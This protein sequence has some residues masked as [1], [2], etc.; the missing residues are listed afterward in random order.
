MSLSDSISV[1]N[2]L[3]DAPSPPIQFTSKQLESLPAIANGYARSLDFDLLPITGRWVT[4]EEAW[5][6]I[7]VELK[8]SGAGSTFSGVSPAIA[9]KGSVLS[10]IDGISIKTSA[11][12]SLVEE[13]HSTV[14]ANHLRL[15][16]ERPSN[17]FVSNVD[18][19]Q[20]A[21]DRCESDVQSG[22]DTAAAIANPSLARYAAA[23]GVAGNGDNAYYNKGFATRRTKLL[24]SLIVPQGGVLVNTGLKTVLN[25]KLS[26]IHSFFEAMNFPIVN[27][28]LQMTFYCNFTGSGNSSYLP[29]CRG[30]EPTLVAGGAVHA[31]D[32]P[33]IKADVSIDVP[34]IWYH[35]L[36][37]SPEQNSLVQAQLEKG[38]VKKLR[39]SITD[40][41]SQVRNQ[42]NPIINVPIATNILNPKR[43]YALVQPANAVVDGSTWPSPIAT[44]SQYYLEQAN[45]MV[46]NRL[47]HSQTLE[48]DVVMYEALKASMPLHGY[49]GVDSDFSLSDFKSM[50]RIVCLD[51]SR[52]GNATVDPQLPV[53]LMFVGKLAERGGGAV[54][55]DVNFLIEREM[56][57]V[58]SFGAGS[59]TVVS[60]P[61][62]FA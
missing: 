9:F 24:Q 12:T 25:I 2:L 17:W 36:E 44:G 22:L 5:L 60:G 40:L 33:S 52:V 62:L 4:F 14:F 10:L 16:L 30:R 26:A 15:A 37:F 35:A 53:S 27:C 28:R 55:C 50:F 18:S 6:S 21:K 11:G 41:Y 57:T 32:I 8:G 51:I 47:Y 38:F 54:A 42:V 61:Q 1:H 56:Q 20:Y 13:R 23:P 7:P 46:N 3:H 39:Y 49:G 19:L 59:F 31:D 45:V 48:G 29:L 43:I 58:F 34:R